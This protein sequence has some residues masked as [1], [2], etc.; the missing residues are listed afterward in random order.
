[1]I[2]PDWL[3]RSARDP[4]GP[5]RPNQTDL[6]R[7]I[8]NLYYSLFHEVCRQTADLHV[9]ASAAVRGSQRYRLIY[10]SIDHRQAKSVFADLAKYGSPGSVAA[11]L[12]Q[13]FVD[14][15]D[16]RHEADYDP[17][18]RYFRAQVEAFALDVA[19]ALPAIRASFPEKKVTLTRLIARGARR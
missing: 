15:Q 9:G 13:V 5:G 12:G 8:F 2:D 17:H 3:L 19:W 10:R 11:T 7:S 6:R 18:A 14:L 1:M 4:R 16:A